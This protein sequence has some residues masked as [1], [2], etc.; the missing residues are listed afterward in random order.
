MLKVTY[1]QNKNNIFRKLF[2]VY[3]CKVCHSPGHHGYNFFS[4]FECL[5]FKPLQRNIHWHVLHPLVITKSHIS[6][7]YITT[8]PIYLTNQIANATGLSRDIVPFCFKKKSIFSELASPF[9]KLPYIDLMSIISTSL[10]VAPR[11]VNKLPTKRF[12]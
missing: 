5:S 3:I 1:F 8:L 2:E 6:V 10:L 11:R 7:L 4:S 9:E 12:Q